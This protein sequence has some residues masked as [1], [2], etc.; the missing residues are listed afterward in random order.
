MSKYSIQNECLEMIEAFSD[1]QMLSDMAVIE[2]VL[3]IFDK[4][5]LM[6]ELSNTDIDI[7][8][9]SM[10][11]ESTFFQE[12]KTPS[13]GNDQSQT[14]GEGGQSAPAAQDGQQQKNGQT[15]NNTQKTPP[16]EAERKKYNSEHQFR[17]MNKKGNIENIFISIIAFIPRL[18]GFLVQC[19]VKLFKKIFNKEGDEAIKTASNEAKSQTPEDIKAAKQEAESE[20]PDGDGTDQENGGETAEQDSA[21]PKLGTIDENTKLWWWYKENSF[22][23]AINEMSKALSGINTENFETLSQSNNIIQTAVA[24]YQ[25]IDRTLI[26]YDGAKMIDSKNNILKQFD[27]LKTRVSATEESIKNFIT[28]QN[29]AGVKGA[30]NVSDVKIAKALCAQIRQFATDFSKD[31]KKIDK[32]YQAALKEAAAVNKR[33]K[34]KKQNLEPQAEP[35]AN[36]QGGEN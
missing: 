20:N 8:D 29:Q 17:Q 3:D 22:L 7:P 1:E 6:M 26:G 13:T 32:G 23:E 21:G 9:C 12:D 10:F 36:N 19:V 15:E 35:A 16:T 5:I 25:S 31:V 18:L 4:T 2:S 24:K 27:F 28:R 34:K 14:G 11:M 33:S 30:K